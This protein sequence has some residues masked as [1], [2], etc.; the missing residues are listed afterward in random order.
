[1]EDFRKYLVNELV[2]FNRYRILNCVIFCCSL[3]SSSLPLLQRK[4]G[5]FTFQKF[6]SGCKSLLLYFLSMKLELLNIQVISHNF[7]YWRVQVVLSQYIGV[8]ILM[9]TWKFPLYKKYNGNVIVWRRGYICSILVQLLVVP[10][11]VL[12]SVTS[13]SLVSALSYTLKFHAYGILIPEEQYFIRNK[14]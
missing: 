11:L 10:Y 5:Y 8:G 2:N 4:K 13:F 1:M 3:K 6:F 12:C 14:I 7:L 9:S